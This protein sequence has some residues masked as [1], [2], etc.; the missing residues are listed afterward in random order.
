MAGIQAAPRSTPQTFAAQ[1]ADLGAA[2]EVL[3][4]GKLP[5]WASRGPV[6]LVVALMIAAGSLWWLVQTHAGGVIRDLRYAKTWQPAYDLQVVN[7][8]CTRYQFVV[9]TCQAQ[10]KSAADPGKPALAIPFMMAFSGGGGER[11]VPV[12]S[13]ADPSAVTI[14]YA[15]EGKLVNRVLTLAAMAGALL[16]LLAAT[17][18]GLLRGRFRNGSAHRALLAGCEELA[19]RA[20]RAAA[21]PRQPSAE[22]G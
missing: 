20:A 17:A 14:A 19:A 22:R 6:T 5:A 11:L 1:P 15:A 21:A 9:T 18:S 8:K 16:A 4:S 12:R 13:T 3:A 2:A 7:G 10:I